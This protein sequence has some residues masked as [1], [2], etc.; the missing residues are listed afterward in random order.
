MEAEQ[1]K[2]F[3]KVIVQKDWKTN[4]KPFRYNPLESNRF[5]TSIFSADLNTIYNEMI[6][7]KLLIT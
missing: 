5:N 7:N 4:F 2:S 6:N 1:F 3:G